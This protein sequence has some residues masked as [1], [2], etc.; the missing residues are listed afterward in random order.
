MGRGQ[1]DVT[2]G[3]GHGVL[4]DARHAVLCHRSSHTAAPLCRDS[5]HPPT[6]TRTV[7]PS[8][9]ATCCC[10][11]HRAAALRAMDMQCRAS[12]RQQLPPWAR[13]STP[14]QQAAQ[15]G[16]GAR[17]TPTKR[18]RWGH[19]LD[20]A[21]SDPLLPSSWRCPRVYDLAHFQQ[22]DGTQPALLVSVDGA[23]VAAAAPLSQEDAA[24]SSGGRSLAKAL[25][26][27]CSHGWLLACPLT[28]EPWLRCAGA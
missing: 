6:H 5:A 20:D 23:V 25:A 8:A 9:A 4:Q 18:R 12:F 3:D 13:P 7:L 21:L 22:L 16:V 1:G 27:Q 14:P 2:W 17:H 19:L 24:A 11:F 10:L 15:V 26:D 28:C